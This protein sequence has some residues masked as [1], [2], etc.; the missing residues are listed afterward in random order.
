MKAVTIGIV[1]AGLGLALA[2]GIRQGF[3][4]ASVTILLFLGIVGALAVAIANRSSR[5]TIAPDVC[6]ECGGVIS[7]NA[8]YCKHCGARSA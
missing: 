1:L 6:A 5:G 4:T 7:P 8:P 3:D 2:L